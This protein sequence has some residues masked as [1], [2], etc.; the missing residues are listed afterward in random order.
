VGLPANSKTIHPKLL[1][2][3]WL[4]SQPNS[5]QVVV[6]ADLLMEEPHVQVGKELQ[7]KVGER[8]HTFVVVGVV[9][10]H[11]FGPRIYMDFTSLSRLSGRHN[12]VD[13]I[14]VLAD[15]NKLGSLVVQ[16]ELADRLQERFRNAGISRSNSVTRSSFFSEFTEV[17]NII[18]FVLLLMAGLLALVGSLGLSGTLG[19]NIMERMREIGVLRAVGAANQALVKIVLTESIVVS[20]V[21]WLMGAITSAISSPLLAAVVIYAVLETQ[22]NFRYSFIGLLIW[23]GVILLIGVFASL[24]PARRAALLQVREVLDYE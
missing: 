24:L 3:T 12:E 15:E 19:I 7:I 1:A 13:E 22:M 20:L 5:R 2:G 14:R 16:N 6:N 11:I 23:F 17:F 21:S 9:S 10:K 4:S 18:L 8:T